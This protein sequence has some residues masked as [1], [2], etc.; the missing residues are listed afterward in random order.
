MPETKPTNP[1]DLIGLTKLPLFSVVPPSSLAYE[2]WAM[3][4]GASKY[5]PFNWREKG[6]RISIYIDAAIRHILAY[7]DGEERAQ[8][9][10]V[11]HLA[12]AK[13]CLGII[14]DALETGNVVDDRPIPGT[15]ARILDALR[16]DSAE[17][18][19]TEELKAQGDGEN[20]AA[21]CET[22]GVELYATSM[23]GLAAAFEEHFAEEHIE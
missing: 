12:H 19:L 9:S 10:N 1:K 14:I 22:C 3:R 4:D 6:V 21:E 13:A 11:H 23:P 8:D 15:F 18:K 20:L 2:A 5:G 7:W 16:L 17:E